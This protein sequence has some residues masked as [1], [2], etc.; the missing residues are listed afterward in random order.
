MGIIT[1]LKASATQFTFLTSQIT[2]GNPR[3]IELDIGGALGLACGTNSRW[4]FSKKWC[5]V[6]STASITAGL[7]CVAQWGLNGK[8]VMMDV[9]KDVSLTDIDGKHD[10]VYV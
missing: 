6:P 3:P 1:L 2:L 9:C 10:K 4:W 8:H 5:V 7:G